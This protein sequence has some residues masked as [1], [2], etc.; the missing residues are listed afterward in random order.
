M[1]ISFETGI[2]PYIAREF[3]FG[4]ALTNLVVAYVFWRMQRNSE[5]AA[6]N[7]RIE[8]TTLKVVH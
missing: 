2:T 3:G 7:S 5:L 6:S 8:V 4:L 1:V